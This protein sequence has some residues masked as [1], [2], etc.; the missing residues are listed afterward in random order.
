MGGDEIVASH[1]VVFTIISWNK[2]E[3]S[4][5]SPKELGITFNMA[6]TIETFPFLSIWHS[7]FQLFFNFK[8]VQRKFLSN[9]CVDCDTTAATSLVLVD[10]INAISNNYS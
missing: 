4:E 8:N 9:K 7:D 1:N 5:K 2:E 6:A 3:V 10:E